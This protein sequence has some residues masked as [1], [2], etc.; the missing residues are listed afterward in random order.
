MLTIL[1]HHASSFFLLI[2]DLQF[3]IAVVITQILD[4]IVELVIPNIISIKETKSEM[5][6]HPVIAEIAISECSI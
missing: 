4:P 3:L 2:I 5:E 1:F 6:T